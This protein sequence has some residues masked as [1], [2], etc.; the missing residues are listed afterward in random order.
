[1]LKP[2]FPAAGEAM[3]A[4]NSTL[5]LALT[6]ALRLH[7]HTTIE[8]LISLLDQIDGDPDL[9]GNGDAEHT[10]GWLEHGPQRVGTDNTDRELDT[11]DDEDGGDA[12][13]EETDCNLAGATSDL[14]DEG[15]P[16]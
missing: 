8:A 3:P 5:F 15:Y 12:E 2:S 10:L 16:L 6:P 9:E 11:A 13:P 4:A 1:M 14:E 7:V